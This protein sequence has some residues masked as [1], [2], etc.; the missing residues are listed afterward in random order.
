[1]CFTLLHKLFLLHP[2]HI[3]GPLVYGVGRASWYVAS[4]AIDLKI[5]GQDVEIGEMN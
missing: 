3:R 4:K 1:M 2:T 5:K